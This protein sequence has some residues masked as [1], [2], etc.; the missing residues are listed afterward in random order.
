MDGDGDFDLHDYYLFNLCYGEDVL[1]RTD[2]ACA[3]VQTENTL[4]DLDDWTALET[5]FT[6]PTP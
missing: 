4:V 2:C 1:V 5:L 6:G 3:N